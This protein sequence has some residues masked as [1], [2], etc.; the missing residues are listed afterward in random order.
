MPSEGLGDLGFRG[1]GSR[2]LG[3]R[4]GCRGFRLRG[5]GFRGPGCRGLGIWQ[6][7]KIRGHLILGSL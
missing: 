6:F 1:P 2:G 5:L 7:P 3:F 4:P